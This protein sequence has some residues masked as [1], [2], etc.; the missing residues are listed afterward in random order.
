MKATESLVDFVRQKAEKQ[1]KG[2][3]WDARRAKWQGDI[4]HLYGMVRGWL[5]PLESNRT[6][7]VEEATV[8]LR[9]D[10]LGT[11]KVPEMSILIG[12]QKVAF[13]PKGTLIVGAQGRVDVSGDASVRTL[14]V[15]R[16]KWAIVD[17]TEKVRL[18]PFTEASFRAL[19]EEVMA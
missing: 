9:E 10:Y 1:E 18:I 2:P 17:R 4:A 11:Y 7:R 6:I 3:D 13:H 5:K 12:S 8:T 15:N 16:G 19:L 14:V